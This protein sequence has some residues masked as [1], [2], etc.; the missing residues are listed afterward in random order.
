MEY[1]IVGAI[2]AGIIAIVLLGGKYGKGDGSYRDYNSDSSDSWDS[3]GGF[4]SGGGD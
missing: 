3:D 2:F 1:V 4:D